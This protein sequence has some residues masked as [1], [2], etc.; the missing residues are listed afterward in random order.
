MTADQ[1][2]TDADKLLE[3]RNRNLGSMFCSEY[4]ADYLHVLCTLLDFRRRHE[5]EVLRDDLFQAAAET[6]PVSASGEPFDSSRFNQVMQQLENWDIAVK[7][8][9]KTRIRSYRDVRRDMFRYRLTD[10]TIAFL[11]WLEERRASDLLPQEDDSVNL[12]EF[13]LGSLKQIGRNLRDADSRYS[14]VIF[15]LGD[16]EEKTTRLSRNLNQITIRLGEFL[17]K[18]YTPEEARETVTGLDAYFKYYLQ[19][20]FKLRTGILKELE[21]LNEGNH[22]GELQKCGELFAAEQRTRPQFLRTG[23]RQMEAEKFPE[24]LLAYYGRGGQVDKL[25]SSVHENAM[26]VL[27]KLTSYLKELERRSNRLEFINLRLLELA[28]RPEEFEPSGFLRELLS[29][30][31]AP[32]DMNDADEFQKAE[33]PA[34]RFGSSGKRMPP[35]IFSRTVKL[36][37]KQV[38]THDEMRLRLLSEFLN[39]RYPENGPLDQAMLERGELPQIALLLKYGITGEGRM[40][41]QIGKKLE[42]RQ[43]QTGLVRFPEGKLEGPQTILK[44]TERNG[45]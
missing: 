10:E 12:L 27:G 1:T 37:E 4:A 26:K 5:L 43:E 36:S 30:A 29:P 24:R 44:E 38:E 16:V 18:N 15:A 25:C 32:L 34:P 8:I 7:R 45:Y 13:I 42:I 31:A 23:S 6:H 17:L 11:T 20:L 21:Q 35:R 28:G 33:P 2:I 9:E 41:A 22:P 3:F 14:S 19:Q 40:L 39:R